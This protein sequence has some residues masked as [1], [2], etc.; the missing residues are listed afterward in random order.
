MVTSFEYNYQ[1][2]LRQIQYFI[3]RAGHKSCSEMHSGSFSQMTSSCKC[4]ISFL[5]LLCRYLL[6]CFVIVLRVV[7]NNDGDYTRPAQDEYRPL[8]RKITGNLNCEFLCWPHKIS[9]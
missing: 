8:V 9:V 6:L 4:P 5:L 3:A 2:A 7:S 1:N